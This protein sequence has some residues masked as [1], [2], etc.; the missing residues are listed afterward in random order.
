MSRL[1][2]L[3][4]DKSISPGDVVAFDYKDNSFFAS[5][6]S[7]GCIT[8]C[9]AR[10]DGV[11]NTILRDR[12]FKTLSAWADACIQEHLH[13]YGTRYSAWKRVKHMTSGK[14][15]DDIYAASAFKTNACTKDSIIETLQ[16]KLKDA[17][18]QIAS[19]KDTKQ[20]HASTDIKATRPVLK[21]T[22]K[23]DTA[24]K[25]SV[26]PIL[27]DSP[28]GAYLVLQ[29]LSAVAPE[30]VTEL[31][32]HGLLEFRKM[33]HQFSVRDTGVIAA[34]DFKN[35]EDWFKKQKKPSDRQIANYVYD[36]FQK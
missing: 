2:N 19:I 20:K 21:P 6:D 28:Y 10:R 16:Q 7:T 31:K 30:S 27:M 12:H 4:L 36:F 32:R 22:L 8:S 9:T 5:I 18:K 11:D 33:I 34:P 1:C 29:R 25:V 24:P 14:T 15:M 3:L 17:E 13:E 23:P 35:K 26:K